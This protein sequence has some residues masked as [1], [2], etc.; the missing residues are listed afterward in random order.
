[1]LIHS[2]FKNDIQDR[3]KYLVERYLRAMREEVNLAESPLGR[4]VQ[5]ERDRLELLG[6]EAMDD[7]KFWQSVSYVLR[8]CSIWLVNSESEIKKINWNL[9]PFH[10][11]I[12]GNKLDRG[13]T[14]EGL[15][16]SYM[17]RP[18]SDQIDTVEQRA[19]AFGY[20]TQLLP[21]C[22]FFATAKT[23]K[24]LTEIVHTEDDLRVNLRAYLESGHTVREWAKQIG[25]LLPSG[26]RPSR[27]SVT[28]AL[29]QFN[30][31]GEWHALRR[32]RLDVASKIHN[33]TL[34]QNSGLLVAEKHNF[35]RLEF[36]TIEMTVSELH[37]FLNQWEV[38]PA[39]SG[40][41]HAS[42]LSY[43]RRH[44]NPDELCHV[45]L[46]TGEAENEVRPRVRKW[47]DDIGFINLFQGRDTNPDAIPF[48]K[49]DRELGF[50]EFGEKSVTL[51]I[52]HVTRRHHDDED[53]YTVAIHL[54][55][56]VMFRKI[57]TGGIS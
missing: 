53:L 1:M 14:V 36:R 45:V 44:Q 56:K 48:Y 33:L 15:T 46:L 40:W 28:P 49:G 29:A 47:E 34:I 7:G 11:L 32:P 43:L 10:V 38:D 41:D 21:F 9:A 16:V 37:D 18:A 50:D 5:L 4:V 13:F 24:L 8:E 20:R 23:L 17:N 2:T 30:T 25:L 3:Y 19:R 35:G 6:V 54:G 26:S 55:D 12:G 27:K 51:Q 31:E 42:I 22:Q 57:D 52:H 39:S